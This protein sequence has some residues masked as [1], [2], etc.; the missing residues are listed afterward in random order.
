MPGGTWPPTRM[1]SESDESEGKTAVELK[2]LVTAFTLI[3]MR[4][5]CTV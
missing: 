3:C 1:R 2:L 5:V 4:C